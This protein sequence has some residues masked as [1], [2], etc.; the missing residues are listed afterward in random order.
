MR[1]ETS[2]ICFRTILASED[3]DHREPMGGPPAIVMKTQKTLLGTQ[4]NSNGDS[5]SFEMLD[6]VGDRWP[7]GAEKRRCSSWRRVILFVEI[8]VVK[9]GPGLYTETAFREQE[10][11]GEKE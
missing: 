3:L 4:L 1:D 10:R 8:L 9:N 5:V 6:G 11:E 7:L 2:L